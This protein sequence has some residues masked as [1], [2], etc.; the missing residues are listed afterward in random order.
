[1]AHDN[2]KLA[3]LL[4]DLDLGNPVAETDRLLEVARVET[5]TFR[6]LLGDRVD[7][8]PGTKGSGKSALFTIFVKFLPDSLLRARRVVVAHGV[9]DPGDPVFDAFR[10]EFERLDERDFVAFWCIY[11]VSLAQEQ[12]IKGPRY[13]NVLREVGREVAAFRA[14]CAAA[15]IPEIPAKRSLRAILEW[16]FNVLKTWRPK[17]TYRLPDGQGE[18]GLEFGDNR[19]DSTKETGSPDGRAELPHYLGDVRRTLE[20]ILAK[21]NLSIWLMIDR[22]D[23]IFPRRSQ[24]ERTAL[25]GLLRA[26]RVLSSEPIRVKVFLRDDM[27]E[28][29]VEGDDGFVA[30]THVTARQADTLRWTMEQILSLI[31]KRIFANPQI[32]AYLEIDAERL[33]A[34]ANYRAEI[35]YKVFPPQV[36]LGGR[37]SSTLTWLYKHCADGRGVVT[38]RDVLDLLIRAAQ[39]QQDMC[40]GDAAGSSEWMIGPAALQYGHGELSKR[41]RITYLQA[42]FPHLWPHI[43][44]LVGG[45]AEYSEQALRETLGVDWRV[46]VG[47]LASIG[48]FASTTRH[49]A[50]A[51]T[52]PFLYR[53]GLEVTQGRA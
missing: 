20:E 43:E 29:I 48:I 3:E 37:Q 27:L 22:L 30:L 32:S 13:A 51:Y 26:M 6:D 19:S 35:F 28:H 8:V 47:D 25:R 11:L 39:R 41:K 42:E 38:P 5:S 12:F 21:A 52:I 16:T 17:L 7:L 14:A 53:K 4:A 45:K 31:T 24:L 44:K 18:L 9:D 40:R 33:E 36:H 23:E 2:S 15:R 1:M 49:G 10:D 50:P 34:S 46:L